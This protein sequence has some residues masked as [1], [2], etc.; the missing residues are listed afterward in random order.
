VIAGRI[1]DGDF[2]PYFR[3]RPPD[4]QQTKNVRP[5]IPGLSLFRAGKT[6]AEQWNGTGAG[7]VSEVQTC[8]RKCLFLALTDR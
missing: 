4:V 2:R 8:N 5:Q 1:A 7:K 6:S 3:E